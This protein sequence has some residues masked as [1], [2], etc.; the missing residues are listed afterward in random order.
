METRD[1]SVTLE[2]TH[3]QDEI[4]HNEP[5]KKTKPQIPVSCLVDKI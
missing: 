2:V 4:C 5:K 3:S 1:V